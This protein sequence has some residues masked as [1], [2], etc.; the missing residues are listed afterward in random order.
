V[1]G[2]QSVTLSEQPLSEQDAQGGS[3]RSLHVAFQQMVIIGVDQMECNI[4][5]ACGLHE[6]IQI[7][8]QRS[9]RDKIFPVTTPALL[10]GFRGACCKRERLA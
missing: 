4:D 7:S 3:D 9:R 2:K 5:E 8:S 6:I 1:E 10:F